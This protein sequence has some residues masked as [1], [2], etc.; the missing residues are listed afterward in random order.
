[1]LTG[2]LIES[3]LYHDDDSVEVL[4]LYITPEIYIH[5]FIEH[6]YQSWYEFRSRLIGTDYWDVIK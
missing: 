2:S 5:V 1:M 3:N 6:E 4:G